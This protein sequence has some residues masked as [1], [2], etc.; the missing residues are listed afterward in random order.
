MKEE[1]EE[2]GVIFLRTTPG[3]VG[4]CNGPDWP[5]PRGAL[6]PQ[7]FD[8]SKNDLAEPL[9][10]LSLFFS[11]LVK[12]RPLQRCV[13]MLQTESL[14]QALL[15]TPNWHMRNSENRFTLSSSVCALGRFDGS[16]ALPVTAWR[17][18][19]SVIGIRKAGPGAVACLGACQRPGSSGRAVTKLVVNT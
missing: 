16:R 8:D 14:A 4:R 2:V 13:S 12:P 15:S 9:D 5:D 1:E 18:V 7:F 6:E 3:A 17:D 11:F 10:S 19:A